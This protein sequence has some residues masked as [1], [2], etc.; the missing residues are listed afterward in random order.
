MLIELA[1]NYPKI[2]VLCAW[3]F[4]FSVTLFE[5]T[6]ITDR[7]RD[8]RDILKLQWLVVVGTLYL[9]L[10]HNQHF[11]RQNQL[12]AIAISVF[13]GLSLFLLLPKVPRSPQCFRL[14]AG[15]TLLLAFAALIL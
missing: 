9:V 3:L 8:L 10:E 14:I 4:F 15:T 7:G 5:Q 1:K 11:G 13:F 6:I 2:A 12:V